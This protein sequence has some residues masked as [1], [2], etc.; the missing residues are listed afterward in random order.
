MLPGIWKW[1]TCRM[2]ALSMPMPNALVATI[3]RFAPLMNASWLALRS[4]AG[5]L[6]W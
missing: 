2:S 6:P 5:S 1:I 3:T 4:A